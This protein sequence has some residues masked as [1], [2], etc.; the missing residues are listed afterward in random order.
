[1]KYNTLRQLIRKVTPDADGDADGNPSDVT[2]PNSF[3]FN[4]KY[5]NNGNLRFVLDPNRYEDSQFIYYKYDAVNRIVETGITGATSFGS[6]DPNI[7]DFPTDSDPKD[8]KLVYIYDQEP[9]YGDTDE[10]VWVDATDPGDLNNLKGRLVAVACK[11]DTFPYLFGYTSFSYDNNGNIEW[12]AQDPPGAELGVKKIIYLRFLPTYM[13]A[14]A[15]LCVQYSFRFSVLGSGRCLKASG[16]L[17]FFTIQCL[18]L[19]PYVLRFQSPFL[20]RVR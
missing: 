3:D 14:C 18:F 2:L 19:S 1:M 15:S 9:P 5:D 7:L 8:V 6:A 20:H 10:L 13:R 12:I 11:K 4:Y 17:H 16:S